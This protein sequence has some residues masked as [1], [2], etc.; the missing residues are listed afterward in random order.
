MKKTVVFVKQVLEYH[1]RTQLQKPF[2]LDA[3]NSIAANHLISF[4]IIVLPDQRLADT[5]PLVPG[6]CILVKAKKIGNA[7]VSV[8]IPALIR[9]LFI[10]PDNR[11]HEP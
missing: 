3:F 5:A 6:Q 11:G 2:Y 10:I 9:Q 4:R 8:P 1:L 7:A